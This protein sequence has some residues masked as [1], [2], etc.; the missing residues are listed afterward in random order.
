MYKTGDLAKWNYDGTIS[1]I[2]RKDSQIKLSGYRI[3][4]KEID[5]VINSYPGITKSITQLYE[6]GNQKYLVS[7]FTAHDTVNGSNLTTY[8][9]NKLA[10]YMIPKSLIELKKFPVTVNRKNRYQKSS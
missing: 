2:G 8:L 10:F 9:Q 4:L 1:F 6:D 7:Y 3:E 5:S